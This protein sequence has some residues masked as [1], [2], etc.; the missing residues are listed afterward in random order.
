MPLY[1][2]ISPCK[3]QDVTEKSGIRG[4]GF[5]AGAAWA[6]YDRDGDLDVFVAGYVFL[7][8]NNLPVFGSSQTCSFK[9]IRVQ[10]GPRGLPGESDLFFRNKGDGT[11]EEVSKAVGV[12]DEKKYYGLG[13]IWCDYN[14]DG[15]PDLY[16]ADDGTPNYLYRNNKDGTLTDVGFES[17]TAYSGAGIE[18][19]S[20]GVTWGDYRRRR[21]ARSFRDEFSTTSTTRSIEI[22][23]QKV[24]LMFPRNQRSAPSAFLMSVGELA[25][26]ILITMDGL[27]SLS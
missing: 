9:G 26:S 19:G 8:L 15:W 18:Q 1:R 17:G 7:D 12:S 16:V 22:S 3:F 21:Q 5:M 4:Q 6:D 23:V 14:D 24:S 13:V 20:M 27:I 2:G 11:F 10:C 25:F